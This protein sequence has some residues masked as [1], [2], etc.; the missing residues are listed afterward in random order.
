MLRI[1][2]K[3]WDI[4]IER[5]KD[6]WMECRELLISFHCRENPTTSLQAEEY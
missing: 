4:I 1:G 6:A 2:S 5:R 3:S